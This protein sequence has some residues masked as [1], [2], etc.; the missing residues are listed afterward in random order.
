MDSHGAGALADGRHW[1][2]ADGELLPHGRDGDGGNDCELGLLDGGGG[3]QDRSRGRTLQPRSLWRFGGTNGHQDY[4]L[5]SLGLNLLIP[6]KSLLLL[7]LAVQVWKKKALFRE[8]LSNGQD[9]QGLLLSMKIHIFSHKT[10]K[11]LLGRGDAFSCS[12]PKGWKG[13]RN[14]LSLQTASVISENRKREGGK[15]LSTT[16][17]T[18]SCASIKARDKKQQT[19]K[20]KDTSHESLQWACTVKLH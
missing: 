4:V 11:Q 3:A 19:V 17:T 6:S 15:E 14:R 9:S 7:Q 18:P 2:V 16:T 8:T 12:L 20:R 5:H 10:A 1:N 13:G